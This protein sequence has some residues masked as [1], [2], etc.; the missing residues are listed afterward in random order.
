MIVTNVFALWYIVKAVNIRKMDRKL[1]KY[2]TFRNLHSA[3]AFKD[4]QDI[5]FISMSNN[6]GNQYVI[7][8]ED[9]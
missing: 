5:K 9:K 6:I 7:F 3:L 4:R 8:Y 2:K 1:T